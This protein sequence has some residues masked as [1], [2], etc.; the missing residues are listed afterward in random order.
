MRIAITYEDGNIFQHFGH[1]KQFMVCDVENG[2]LMS[3][4]SLDSEEEGHEA[5]VNLLKDNEVN[6]LICGGIGAGAI[7]ALMA[8]GIEVFAGYQGNALDVLENLLTGE[9]DP[10]NEPTCDHHNE[11]GCGDHKCDPS[12]CADA[13]EVAVTN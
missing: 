10:T 7:N 11:C 9:D 4:G 6:V 2:E 1:T 13:M 12:S 3:M 8:A 5:I